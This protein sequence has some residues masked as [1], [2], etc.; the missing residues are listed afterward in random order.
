MND[1]LPNF[2]Q[3]SRQFAGA[4]HWRPVPAIPRGEKTPQ[5]AELSSPFS[6][7]ICGAFA[8]RSQWLDRRS[9]DAQGVGS[10]SR[11]H[12]CVEAH[13]RELIEQGFDVAVAKDATAGPRHPEFGDG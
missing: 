7:A 3:M 10:R 6:S 13:M 8:F 5:N 9:R 2:G 12:C 4:F 11:N 1:R